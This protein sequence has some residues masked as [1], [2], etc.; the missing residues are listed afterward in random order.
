MMPGFRVVGV[1][2]P[3]RVLVVLC[4]TQITG[5]GVLF[6]AFPVLARSISADTG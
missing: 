1:T 5:W 6:H 3:A 2:S 4:L